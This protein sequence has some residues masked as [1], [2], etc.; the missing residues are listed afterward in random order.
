MFDGPERYRT[1]AAHM[2]RRKINQMSKF[3]YLQREELIRF[4]AL[5]ASIQ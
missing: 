2:D 1:D 5:E 3:V 4:W